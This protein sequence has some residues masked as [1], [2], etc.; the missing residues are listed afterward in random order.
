[1]TR[2]PEITQ[3][4]QLAEADR[5]HFDAIAAPRGGITVPYRYLLHSPELASR[6]AHLMSYARFETQAPPFPG[7]VKELVICTAAREMDCAFEWADHEQ[8][9][10]DAGVS[11]ATVDAI[12][13][14]HTPDALR[15]EDAVVVRYV[16]QLLRPP[17][18]VSD[19][20]FN[21]LRER[22]GDTRLVEMTGIIGGYIALACTFNAFNIPAT[23]GLPVLPVQAPMLPEDEKLGVGGAI[24]IHE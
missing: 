15:A 16:Q 4:D 22:L 13:F 2:L 3:R 9:A 7:D 6:M 18:R 20:V 11:R 12:K 23:P 19:T 10:I 1:M 14:R 5:H 8:R 21:T 17:H 24:R